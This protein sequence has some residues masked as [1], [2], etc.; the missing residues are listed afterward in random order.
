L[1]EGECNGA[2]RNEDMK[3]VAAFSGVVLV[4]IVLWDAFET[5]IL[6][7]RVTRKYRLTRF[8]YRYTW[9]FWKSAGSIFLLFRRKETYMAFYGPLSIILL[10][11][12]WA[13]GIIL[14]FAL[15]LAAGSPINAP[16]E[17]A[18]FF[19]DFYLSGKTFFTL[20]MGDVIP[21]SRFARLCAVAE[22]GLGLG[23]LAIVI[24]YL[25]ALNQSF[26]RRE[27]NISLLDARAGSPPSAFELLRRRCHDP[28][29]MEILLQYLGEWERWAADLLES[30]LSYPVLAYFRSQHDNQSWLAALT[31]ILDASAFV[32]VGMEGACERQARLTFAIAR[33]AV[34]DLSLV[35]FSPPS[36]S[37]HDRLPHEDFIKLFEGLKSS[38]MSLQERDG[39]EEE[40]AELRKMYEPYVRSLSN[41]L[42]LS[43]PHWFPKETL[44]DNWQTS[45]WEKQQGA[46]KDAGSGKGDGLHFS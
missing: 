15:L 43:V 40:L 21:I 16:G 39:I 10:L 33:H 31:T 18:D 37:R 29:G 11:S 42:H 23:L 22:S 45:A 24:S 38:G 35:F 41:Y 5:I 9:F 14:G 4:L 26:S 46:E 13:L 34:V 32:I 30:H 25:P 44:T 8:F 1:P 28:V 7:R 17:T 36:K 12:V 3:I 20:G 6:P 2:G 27:V 19:T